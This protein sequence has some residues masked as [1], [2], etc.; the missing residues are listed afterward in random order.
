MRRV[1]IGVRPENFAQLLFLY[2]LPAQ[3]DHGLEQLQRLVLCP[4]L[5]RMRLTVNDQPEPAQSI[6]PDKPGPVLHIQILGQETA[7]EDQALGVVDFDAGPQS[8]GAKLRHYLLW[9][10][11]IETAEKVMFTSD[12]KG[13]PQ[14]VVTLGLLAL[15]EIGVYLHQ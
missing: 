6:N 7:L 8:L 4:G 13:F 5:Q 15:P 11:A 9:K 3:S 2:V 12:G 1:A 14:A 10:P